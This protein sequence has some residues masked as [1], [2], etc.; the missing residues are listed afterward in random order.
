MN[1]KE[2]SKSKAKSVLRK[3][4]AGL[5]PLAGSLVSSVN[6]F[7]PETTRETIKL[8]TFGLLKIP[9]LFLISPTV[10]EVSEEKVEVRIPLNRRTR[11]HLRSMY[12]GVLAAGADCACGALTFHLI[13]KMAKGHV[14]L[15]FKDFKAEFLKRAEGDVVFTCVQG[16]LI[17]EAIRLALNTKERQSIPV[18]VT[19]TVP[20]KLGSEPVARFVLT[21]SLKYQ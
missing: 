20:S 17:Q 15:I 13:D 19:A 9:V 7:L 16:P 8:R 4:R 5:E 1:S 18:E 3:L 21:L 10:L 2:A 12:F 14:N 6:Q 11:N